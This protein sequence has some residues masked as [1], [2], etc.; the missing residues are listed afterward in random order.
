[1]ASAPSDSR[2]TR[3]RS[4]RSHRPSAGRWTRSPRNGRG[5][6]DRPPDPGGLADAVGGLIGLNPEAPDARGPIGIA[7]ETGRVLEAPLVSQLFFIGLLSVNLAVLNVLPFPPLDGGRIAVV[8]IEAVRR[9]RLPAEREA[10]I[11]LTGFAVLIALVILISIQDIQRLITGALGARTSPPRLIRRA[12]CLRHPYASGILLSL[13]GAALPR[14]R[15][16]ARRH[17]RWCRSGGVE[18]ASTIPCRGRWRCGQHRLLIRCPGQRVRQREQQPEAGAQ[19]IINFVTGE[20]EVVTEGLQRRIDQ[21]LVD[22]ATGEG[23][24]GLFGF[25][26]NGDGIVDATS[27]IVGPDDHIPGLAQFNGPAC[28]GVTNIGVFFS[29]CVG[30]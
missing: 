22:P 18:H 20:V 27:Y 10:I 17:D 1:M 28:H 16:A 21:G 9:R 4:S 29:Q 5:L 13:T 3:P 19:A 26:F 8:L 14:R 15:P 23:F 7:Q 11:Y 24:H 6:D 25:D 2:T 12:L 30:P